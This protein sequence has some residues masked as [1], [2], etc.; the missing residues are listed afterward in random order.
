MSGGN[1][2]SVFSEASVVFNTWKK[3]EGKDSIT[4][5]K[6]EPSTQGL[7]TAGMLVLKLNYR[8]NAF[9]RDTGVNF[10]SNH[11]RLVGQKG[12][13]QRETKIIRVSQ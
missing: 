2:I 5:V 11:P 7:A 13:E 10:F 4:L 3:M 12:R 9:A 1:V 8:C 6:N